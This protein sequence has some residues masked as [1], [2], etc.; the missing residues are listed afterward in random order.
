LAAAIAWAK[1]H[2]AE[3]AMAYITRDESGRY[4]STGGKPA[5][6]DVVA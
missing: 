5:F 2:D 1:T 4:G 6:V 3:C